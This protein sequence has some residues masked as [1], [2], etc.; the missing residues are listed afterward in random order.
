MRVSE[1][2]TRIFRSAA[3]T[4]RVRARSF[5]DGITGDEFDVIEDEE[6]AEHAERIHGK[7]PE[8]EMD[9]RIGDSVSRCMPVPAM[10]RLERTVRAVTTR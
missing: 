8:P 9:R 4:P 3:V 10:H 2:V 1:I 6:I 5:E 7:N